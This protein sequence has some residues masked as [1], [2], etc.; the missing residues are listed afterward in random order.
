MNKQLAIANL[1]TLNL[2]TLNLI[3][4]IETNSTR[5]SHAHTKDTKKF[6]TIDNII[7]IDSVYFYFAIHHVEFYLLCLFQFHIQC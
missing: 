2:M 5:H 1:P 4:R 7:K 3:S 6:Q